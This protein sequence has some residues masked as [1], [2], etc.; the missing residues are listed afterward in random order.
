MSQTQLED[1]VLQIM[2]RYA[3]ELVRVEALHVACN[4]EATC[5]CPP[6]AC[7]QLLESQRK[8]CELRSVLGEFLDRLGYTP[9]PA[10]RR[11]S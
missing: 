10:R 9:Q 6:D 5:D 7:Q 11:L 8:M 2:D 4:R 1:E 3:D